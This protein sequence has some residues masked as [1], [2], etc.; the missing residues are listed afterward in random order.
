M[1]NEFQ[2]PSPRIHCTI[3]QCLGHRDSDFCLQTP[4]RLLLPN[5]A[6]L[7]SVPLPPIPLQH[8]P[9]QQGLK[10]LTTNLVNCEACRLASTFT[11]RPTRQPRPAQSAR[12]SVGTSIFS[13]SLSAQAAARLEG[14]VIIP[15]LR[16]RC[17]LIYSCLISFNFHSG[18]P[19]SPRKNVVIGQHAKI[20]KAGVEDPVG[21]PLFVI[22]V[23]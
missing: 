16:E 9:R 15:F 12:E 22:P 4:P 13:E 18:N 21:L 3:A 14:N 20:V 11:T 23:I 2:N 5:R 8:L 1:S 6:G 19:P 7:Q 10:R 17:W